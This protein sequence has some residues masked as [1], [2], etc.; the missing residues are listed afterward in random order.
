MSLNYTHLLIPSSSEFRPDADAVARFVRGLIDNGNVANGAKVAF[1]RVT[2][3]QPRVRQMR[4]PMT[5]ETIDLRGPSRT[6]ERPR[7]LS[8]PSQIT[9]HAANQ[10]EFDVLLTGEG[11]PSVPPLTVGSVEDGDWKVMDGAY[12]LEVRCRIRANVVRLYMLDSEDDLHRPPAFA[13]YRP[14]YNEDC[15]PAENA[16]GLYV[17]PEIGAFR[18]PN[19]G[20]G[21]FWIEFNYGKFVFPRLKDGSVDVLADSVIDLARAAFDCDFIQACDW[22]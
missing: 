2:K 18:V 11:V 19:A 10:Q 4:N 22:G 7:T 20:C 17:H 6:L 8:D 16:D 9:E 1:A 13:N 5:G 14:K 3:G 12:H 21:M 15:S